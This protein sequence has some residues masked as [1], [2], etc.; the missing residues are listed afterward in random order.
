MGELWMPGRGGG[1]R[2]WGLEGQEYGMDLGR[3]RGC[4]L[5]IAG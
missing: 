1:W 2:G 5:L 3:T 4:W